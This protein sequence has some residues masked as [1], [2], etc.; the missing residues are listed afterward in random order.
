M[1]TNGKQETEHGGRNPAQYAADARP[2][3]AKCENDPHLKGCE[4]YSP[5][6]ICV[7]YTGQITG[8]SGDLNHEC[9][10]RGNKIIMVKYNLQ[11]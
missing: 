5:K 8:G 10:H 9:Y 11:S 7:T 6:N 2:C 4:Y 1:D 3:F